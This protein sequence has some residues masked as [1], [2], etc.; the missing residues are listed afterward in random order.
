MR[1][2]KVI[3]GFV[4]R[5]L[6]RFGAYIVSFIVSV[7]L[8][9]I[10]SPEMFGTI[11]IVTVFTNI[12]QVFVDT[13]LGRA[14]IQKKEVDNLD[15]S[16][17]FYFN[18]LMCF[19][20][21]CVMYLS[22]PFIARFYGQTN[23]ITIIRVLSV[24]LIISGL[25]NVQQAYVSREMLFKRFFWATLL[26]T[27]TS[28]VIGI[29]MA[30]AGAGVWA[31]VAQ[32]LTN[33]LID[34]VMLWLTV[35]WRPEKKFSLIRL[36]LLFSYGWKLLIAGLVGSLSD[37]LRQLLIGKLYTSADLAYF[38]KGDQIPS[39]VNG[40]VNSAID[41]VIFPVL[42][43][44]QDDREKVK[45]IT[46]KAIVTSMYIMA[47]VFVGLFCCA[48][49]LVSLLFTE[50]W[51]P[52]VPYLRIFCL[53]YLFY[54]IHTA[55]LNAILAVGRSDIDLKLEVIKKLLEI[56]ILILFMRHGV[57]AI[58]YSMIVICV[59]SQI[60]NTW[61]N[62]KLIG[63]G[64]LEQLHDILP[65]LILA[66]VMG[67]SIYFI[68]YLRIDSWLILIVQVVLGA[69]IYIGLS[70]IMKLEP[71]INLREKFKETMKKCKKNS[72][73]KKINAD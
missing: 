69:G 40:N 53:T 71:Y 64:Y 20:L 51:L 38:N 54:P 3:S 67:V 39:V 16:S 45:D 63:Y 26:G 48:E 19:I 73:K 13:G 49:T 15:F 29:W 50:K 18:M 17:V 23:L 5:F 72:E 28:A 37:N 2:D 36:K 27:L 42:S 43:T 65:G 62:K 58:A 9:R 6:E 11:A 68:G 56:M 61:P 33:N 70:A 60:I 24:T 35:K 41:S 55:N 34:T 4:W 25:K 14:L 7:V 46:H 52:C 47:P 66:C 21:Y 32:S 22:A 30:Y 12:L 57:M 44:V 1:R 8:A 59:V 31:L 10:L